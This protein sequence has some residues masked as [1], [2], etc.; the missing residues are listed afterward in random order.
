MAVLKKRGAEWEYLIRSPV[1]KQRLKA[2]AAEAEE[3]KA[4]LRK[5][6]KKLKQQQRQEKKHSIR[7]MKLLRKLSRKDR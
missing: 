1:R 2:E 5:Q 3:A 4:K 7:E 6:Q